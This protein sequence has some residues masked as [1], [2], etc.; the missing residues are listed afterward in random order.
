[1]CLNEAKAFVQA[2]L[3][4]VKSRHSSIYTM[5]SMYCILTKVHI[6]FGIL[7]YMGLKNKKLNNEKYTKAHESHSPSLSYFPKK[8]DRL[9]YLLREIVFFFSQKRFHYTRNVDGPS[10]QVFPLYRGKCFVFSQ[11]VRAAL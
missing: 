9:S 11:K 7:V 5:Y 10:C 6:D 4:V 8:F 1:M 3:K 2:K